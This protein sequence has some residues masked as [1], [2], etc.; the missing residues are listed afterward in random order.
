[1]QHA[2]ESGALLPIAEGNKQNASQL[3]SGCRCKASRHK[4]EPDDGLR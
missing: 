1:M 2:S 3:N 4:H